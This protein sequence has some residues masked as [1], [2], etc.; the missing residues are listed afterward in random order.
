MPSQ[1]LIY[2]D[3]RGGIHPGTH[4][5]YGA[6]SSLMKDNIYWVG[7]QGFI[8]TSPW[9][10]TQN[11]ARHSAVVLL[12]ATDEPMELEVAGCRMRHSA[13]AVS[14][15]V[16]RTLRARNI[17]LVSV[18]ISPFHLDYR[19]FRRFSDTGITPLAREKYADLDPQLL[20]AYEGQTSLSEADAL[21]H[22]VVERTVAQLPIFYRRSSH[23]ELVLQIMESHP[24]CSLSELSK[25]LGLSN[26]RTTHLFSSAVGLS[27]KSY[28]FWYKSAT[29]ANLLLADNSLTEVAHNAG[30]AD[31]AH[32]S[33][34][35]RNK[36]GTTPSY[37]R[38]DRCVQLFR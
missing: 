29:A 16:A 33:R 14:P 8:Y 5:S 34:T 23:T 4:P 36:F 15:L 19:A 37:I 2:P 3:S 26:S 20:R 28:M 17:G 32:L 31:S 12:S 21:F 38:N 35:W 7:N 9:V 22:A 25:Q 30:F 6:L 11:T 1:S 18:N 10:V 27:L 13:F 24:L